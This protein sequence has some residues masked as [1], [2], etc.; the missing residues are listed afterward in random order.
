[1]TTIENLVL[2]NKADTQHLPKKSQ[3]SITDVLL[4]SRKSHNSII[5]VLEVLVHEIKELKKQGSTNHEFCTK[6]EERIIPE[7]KQTLTNTMTVIENRATDL[8]GHGFRL[9]LLCR[10]KTEAE[11]ETPAQ[12]EETFRRICKDLLQIE[13]ADSI[14]F[15]DVHRLPAPKRGTGSTQPKPIIAAF[16]LMKDRNEVL[17]K[18]HLLKETG[19]SLQSHLPKPLNDLRNQMLKKRRDM[20]SADPTKKVRV[21]DR[22]Y[23]PVLQEKLPGEESYTTIKFDPVGVTRDNRGGRGGPRRSGRRQTVNLEDDEH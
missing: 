7:V 15:R 11:D 6:L 19:L 3:I 2:P 5:D 23:T 22:N 10:G 13:N 21:V 14:L 20:L 12:T 4:E 1:M 16:I 9:N 8:Q 17:S 18:A